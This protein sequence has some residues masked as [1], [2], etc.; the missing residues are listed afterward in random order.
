[1]LPS[2]IARMLGQDGWIKSHP[3]N[4]GAP[5]ERQSPAQTVVVM[6]ASKAA[7]H[8]ESASTAVISI[9]GARDPEIPLSTKYRAVLRLAFDDISAFADHS[10]DDASISDE[11]AHSVAAF[12]RA[13]ADADTLLL[14]CAA[15]VSRSRSMAAAICD[16]RGLPY[17]WTVINDDVYRRVRVALLESR[18]AGIT[19]EADGS[20]PGHRGIP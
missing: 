9:R 10:T 19:D 13:H 6:S 14:H 1:M 3:A 2:H 7:R 16:V 17:E 18:A 12:V 4:A 8:R 11:Q 15:G 5:T 20:G